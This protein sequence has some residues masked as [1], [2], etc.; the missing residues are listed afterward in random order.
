M[1]MLAIRKVLYGRKIYFIAKFVYTCPYLCLQ[2]LKFKW[3]FSVTDRW[4]IL[5]P[6]PRWRVGVLVSH[7]QFFCSRVQWKELPEKL[8]FLTLLPFKVGEVSF[9]TFSNWPGSILW[10]YRSKSHGLQCRLD[11]LVAGMAMST[12]TCCMYFGTEIVS[13]IL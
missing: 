1:R 10:L 13:K 8:F 6:N 4:P 11:T 9:Q 5:I 3:F 7:Q 12:T 2:F